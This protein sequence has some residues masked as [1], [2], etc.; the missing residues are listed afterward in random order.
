MLMVLLLWGSSWASA[1]DL[2]CQLQRTTRVCVA[3]PE[4]HSAMPMPMAAG[5][6]H[7]PPRVGRA[8]VQDSVSSNCAAMDCGGAVLVSQ[9]VE[10]RSAASFVPVAMD[11]VR[12]AE[13][14]V[15]EEAATYLRADLPPDRASVLHRRL[16]SLRI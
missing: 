11:F 4:V 15:P 3:T 2:S 8:A 16:V 14:V 7:C 13:F 10:E 6:E 9:N 1:C 5:C 12:V